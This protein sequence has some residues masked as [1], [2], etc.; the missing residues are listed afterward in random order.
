MGIWITERDRE[1]RDKPVYICYNPSQ[2]EDVYFAVSKIINEIDNNLTV[3][4]KTKNYTEDE[5]NHDFIYSRMFSAKVMLVL[6]GTN[7][8]GVESMDLEVSIAQLHRLPLIFINARNSSAIYRPA[9]I[10]P[11]IPIYLWN[12]EKLLFL[13]KYYQMPES[14]KYGM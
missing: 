5:R 9:E 10:H 4:G 6:C 3:C 8:V 13:L 12:R 7:N 2:E 11:W 1:P 14:I